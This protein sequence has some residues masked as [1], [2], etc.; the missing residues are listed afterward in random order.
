MKPFSIV[1]LIWKPP[2]I[3]NY[4]D[5]VVDGMTRDIR[6]FHENTSQPFWTDAA[7][8][9][10]LT[11]FQESWDCISRVCKELSFVTCPNFLPLYFSTGNSGVLHS[12][13]RTDPCS[14]VLF[15][16]VRNCEVLRR[17]SCN[18]DS[19]LFKEKQFSQQRSLRDTS[20]SVV[21]GLCCVGV[22][23]ALCCW[24]FG[25]NIQCIWDTCCLCHS[26]FQEKGVVSQKL[27]A[28]EQK[29]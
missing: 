27:D 2:D 17:F 25:T 6:T 11:Y 10:I 23:L 12:A 5:A 16:E 22:H 28:S 24:F 13:Y 7:S 18:R 4:G 21:S 3:V 8:A 1:L 9:A 19:S 15:L 29:E 26:I 20:V 14:N